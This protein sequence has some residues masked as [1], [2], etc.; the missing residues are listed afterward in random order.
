[1]SWLNLSDV[2]STKEEY[3]ELEERTGNVENKVQVLQDASPMDYIVEQGTSGIWT[4]R[5]W[6]SGVAECW[7]STAAT[8][9]SIS[10][11]WGSIF[12]KDKAIASQSFPFTFKNAPVLQISPKVSNSNFWIYTN[13][14]CTVDKTGA[15]GV[16]RGSSNSSVIVSAN[17]YAIGKWENK[18]S[19]NIPAYVKEEALELT[20]KVG[21]G[22]D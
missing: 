2:F 7:G 4:Y 12:V 20:S 11:A 21:G 17:F 13:E 15:F 8:T 9:V 14:I 18:E 19:D 16:A 10:T 6:N 5:K 1:M 3:N 22:T